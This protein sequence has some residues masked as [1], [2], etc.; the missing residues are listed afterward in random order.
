MTKEKF[1]KKTEKARTPEELKTYTEIEMAVAKRSNLN[2]TE[3]ADHYAEEYGSLFEKNQEQFL[4]LFKENPEEL[5][6]LIKAALEIE[7]GD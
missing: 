3:W 7:D 1:P 4:K 2:S 5:F 6:A